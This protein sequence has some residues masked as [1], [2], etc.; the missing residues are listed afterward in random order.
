MKFRHSSETVP[1]LP[2]VAVAVAG[3]GS[4]P[5]ADA[6][7]AVVDRR[8][9]CGTAP[10]LFIRRHPRRKVASAGTSNRSRSR[11]ALAAARSGPCGPV[12]VAALVSAVASSA[13]SWWGFILTVSL[14]AR[15]T[16]WSSCTFTYKVAPPTLTRSTGRCL[17]ITRSMTAG[18]RSGRS[19]S[20][21]RRSCTSPTTHIAR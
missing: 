19:R 18:A 11:I 4:P 14:M 8:L 2:P 9:W 3:P 1:S 20:L 7:A 10:G 16:A 17:Q 6:D 12:T 15:Q 5:V 21:R 13:C